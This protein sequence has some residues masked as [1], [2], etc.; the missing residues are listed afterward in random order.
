MPVDSGST[1]DRAAVLLLQPLVALDAF[2]RVV[3]GLAL[4]PLELHAVD[5]AGHVDE[6][7]V[8]DRAAVVAGAA[9]G[10]GPTPVR[11][12]RDELLVLRNAPR[13]PRRTARYPTEPT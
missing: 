5:A 4:L 7:P 10:I 1:V 8:V 11:Q 6:R 9:G 13:V 3:L 2:R 12:D